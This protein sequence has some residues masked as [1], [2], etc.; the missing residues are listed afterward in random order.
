MEWAETP[1]STKKTLQRSQNCCILHCTEHQENVSTRIVAFTPACCQSFVL[2]FHR[3]RRQRLINRHLPL[4][5]RSMAI[6]LKCDVPNH[7]WR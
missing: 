6:L 3:A 7:E 5:A 2:F 4:P 1:D